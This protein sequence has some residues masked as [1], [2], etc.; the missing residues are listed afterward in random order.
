MWFVFIG[1]SCVEIKTEVDSDD[2]S[3]CP[4]DGKLS[5]GMFGF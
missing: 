3:E 2:V 5:T 4:H 1:G